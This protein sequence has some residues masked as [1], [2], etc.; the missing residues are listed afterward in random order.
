MAVRLDSKELLKIMLD[1]RRD[2][3]Q[4]ELYYRWRAVI[5]KAMDWTE[6]QF[7]LR[8]DKAAKLKHHK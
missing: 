3:R 5:A 6:D 1:M 8:L 2:I 4:Q 7:E